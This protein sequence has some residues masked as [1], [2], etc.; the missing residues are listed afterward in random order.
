M[1]VR[2][3]GG[4]LYFANESVVFNRTSDIR[5]QHLDGDL[6]VVPNVI[7]EVDCGHAPGAK[8]PINP[9]AECEGFADAGERAGLERGAHKAKRRRVGMMHNMQFSAT[10]C[11]RLCERLC[12]RGPRRVAVR[13]RGC[14][15]Q[16]RPDL[17]LPSAAML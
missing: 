13:V 4:E 10:T 2:E 11:D 14:G 1:C 7:R 15:R 6:A 8:F 16:D 12:G 9:I 5:M 17:S 3:T